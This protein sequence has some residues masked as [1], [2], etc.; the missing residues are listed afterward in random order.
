MDF[1]SFMKLENKD[2]VI[3][4]LQSLEGDIQANVIKAMQE[5]GKEIK[6]HL[7]EKI[8]DAPE[9][10]ASAPGS[11]PFSQ[12][13]E[14]KSGI[15]AKVLPP[16]LGEPITLK[17]SVAGFFAHMLEFGTSKMAARPWFYTGIAEKVPALFGQIRNTLSAVIN[18]RNTELHPKNARRRN[19][20]SDQLMGAKEKDAQKLADFNSDYGGEN[21]MD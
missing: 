17:I 4:S 6:Q 11:A 21:G 16:M 12:T 10:V 19:W 9:G 20:T 2:A 5:G 15:R 1:N 13:G 18:R 3:A 8:K 14:L 7:K